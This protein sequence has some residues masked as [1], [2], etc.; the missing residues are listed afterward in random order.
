[1]RYDIIESHISIAF[2]T[3]YW[4]YHKGKIYSY[5]LAA[6]LLWYEQAFV[7]TTWSK[8]EQQFSE[9]SPVF[10]SLYQSITRPDV[11]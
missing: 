9:I 4:W 7:T 1:M 2:D 10:A 5:N 3:G 8:S 11:N 6:T